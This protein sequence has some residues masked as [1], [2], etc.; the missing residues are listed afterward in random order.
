MRIVAMALVSFEQSRRAFPGY[1]NVVKN[2]RASYVVPILAY[3]ERS[4][5]YEAWHNLDPVPLPLPKGSTSETVEDGERR[6]SPWASAEIDILT[7]PSAPKKLQNPDQVSYAVNC[8]SA[9]TANDFLPPITDANTWVEDRNSGVFFNRAR[10]DFRLGKPNPSPSP[11]AFDS[12]AGPV[13]TIDFIAAHD[14]T[15]YTLLLSENLQATSWATDPTDTA[16]QPPYPFQSEFQIRQNTGFVWFVTGSSDNALPVS[17]SAAFNSAAIGVNQLRDVATPVPSA[18]YP[19]PGSNPPTG[20]LAYA[21]PSSNHPG[22]VNVMFCDAHLRFISDDIDYRAYTQLM[23]PNGR[24]VIVELPDK[25]AR[26]SGWN[27]ELR[28]ADY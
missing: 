24:D 8:G 10:A 16:H 9:R 2:K 27:Y 1:A 26:A 21:R 3:L 22:G 20:G 13:I 5:L 14:G 25:T 19:V 4:D 11:D 7:C 12:Q 28:D 23:T 6:P 17:A 15:T 18:A